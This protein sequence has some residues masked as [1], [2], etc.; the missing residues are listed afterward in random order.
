MLPVLEEM[1][2]DEKVRR[3]NLTLKTRVRD[4]EDSL[5]QLIHDEDQVIAA[6]AVHFVQSRGLWKLADDLEYALEHRDPHDWYVFEAASWAL[7]ARRMDDAAPGRGGSN[8]CRLS[9][10]WT[11]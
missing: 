4:A 5:A 1:P 2:I 6:T 11:S 7:A 9:C 8:R 10:S 3:G